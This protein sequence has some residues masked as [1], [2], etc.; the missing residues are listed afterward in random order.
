VK[1]WISAKNAS[2]GKLLQLIISLAEYWTEWL[3]MMSS[4]L[5]EPVLLLVCIGLIEQEYLHL[6][7]FL[8]G[9]DCSFSGMFIYFLDILSQG[10]FFIPPPLIF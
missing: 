6:G 3:K 9:G 5:L 10:N 1:C 2:P 4:C 7:F 8:G